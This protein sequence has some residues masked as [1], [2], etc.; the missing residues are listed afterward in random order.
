MIAYR[1]SLVCEL[2]AKDILVEAYKKKDSLRKQA[3]MIYA[4][5]S[6]VI[7]KKFLSYPA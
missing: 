6:R 1:L 7:A 5:F 2:A 3:D 4:N